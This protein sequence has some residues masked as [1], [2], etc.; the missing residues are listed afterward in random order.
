MSPWR[1]AVF[2]QPRLSGSNG[3]RAI[4]MMR[5][6]AGS[7]SSALTAAIPISPVG[8]VTATVS[9]TAIASQPSYGRELPLL[10]ALRD[11]RDELPTA[12][13]D[14][15]DLRHLR[16]AHHGRLVGAF[17]SAAVVHFHV[18]DDDVRQVGD[19]RHRVG[20][21]GVVA[22]QDDPGA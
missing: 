2:D 17:M 4:P 1:Y 18:Q 16:A 21:I 22:E 11:R 5:S 13:D 3:R 15:K 20:R 8:P 9:A 19:R 7:A 14:L 12:A 6:T 10:F